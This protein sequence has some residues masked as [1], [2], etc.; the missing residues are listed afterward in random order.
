M[1][2]ARLA[3]LALMALG[4]PTAA[5][6][7]SI[8]TGTFNPLLSFIGRNHVGALPGTGFRAIVG[9]ST[10]R[11]EIMTG[12][13]TTTGGAGCS[14][15]ANGSCS[16]STGTMRV[17]SPTPGFTNSLDDGVVNKV[18]NHVFIIADI[19]PSTQFPAGGIVR[20]SVTLNPAGPPFSGQPLAGHAHANAVPE[21]S[22]LLL[23]GTGLVGLAG[24]MRRKLTLGT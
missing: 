24:T 14:T 3:A 22:S 16:F 2:Q 11:I 23:L 4:L 8:D 12:A 21:P 20:M 18:G 13:L 19:M 9:G 17:I 5:L 6:A 7:N 15:A 10:G 1:R